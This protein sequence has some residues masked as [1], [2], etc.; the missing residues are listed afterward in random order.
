MFSFKSSGRDGSLCKSRCEIHAFTPNTDECYAL[1]I[2]LD[3]LWDTKLKG[4]K[5][6]FLWD[7]EAALEHSSKAGMFRFQSRDWYIRR[8]SL[9]KLLSVS[10]SVNNKLLILA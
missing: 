5:R 9:E 10:K 1:E 7:K 6:N 4:Y 3:T 2:F 8:A